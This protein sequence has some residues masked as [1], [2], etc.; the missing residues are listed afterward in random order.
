MSKKKWVISGSMVCTTSPSA[1]KGKVNGSTQGNQN[2]IITGFHVG[3]ETH[4]SAMT[5][6]ITNPCGRQLIMLRL[7]S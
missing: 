4:H 2:Y 6:S 5:S 1:I 3:L 7:C